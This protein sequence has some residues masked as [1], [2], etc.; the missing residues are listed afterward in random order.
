MRFVSALLLAACAALPAADA[1]V[2]V[3]LTGALPLRSTPALFGGEDLSLHQATALLRQALAAPEPAVVLDLSAGFAPGLAAAEELAAVL[4]AEKGAKH[5]TALIDNLDDRGLIVAAACDEVVVSEAG[6]VSAMGLSLGTLYF[7]EALAKAGIVAHA[8]ASGEHKTAHESFTATGPSPAAAADLRRLAAG[9]DAACVALMARPGLDVAAARAQAPQTPAL[10]VRL[11]LADRSAE[12][13]GFLADLPE[14]TRWLDGAAL[15][16]DLSSLGGMLAFWRTMLEG[17]QEPRRPKVVAVVELAGEIMDGSDSTPGET[18]AGDDTAALFDDLAADERVVAVVLRID[19]P[20]GSASASDRI[21]YAVRRCAAKK[22]VV[23]LFDGVAASGGYYIGC[24]AHEIQVHRTTITGS[25]GVFALVPDLTGT[26]D[27]LGI[28]SFSVTTGPR[29]DFDSLTAPFTAD[30]AAAI[31]QLIH[32]VDERFQ[33]LVA[34]ARNLPP[35]TV[36]GLAGGRVFT[37]EEAVANHL[38]DGFGT[39]LTAVKAARA[40]A[41]QEEPLPIERHPRERGLLDRLGL[42]RAHTLATMPGGTRAARW[43]AMLSRPV[44]TVLAW[45]N[46]RP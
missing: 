24:A 13:G 27:W 14:D 26:L 1:T 45:T 18:I 20:G 17:D 6:L 21:H 41:G 34:S 7:K 16:P 36:V 43:V 38:A 33:G 39:L 32:A 37:G 22:P 10:A 9:L 12:V 15:I 28:R 40:R 25:I 11:K 42:G 35:E 23:A 29:A 3:Q 5:L 46:L 19:S 4:R 31:E 2:A 44:P 8:V 30:R